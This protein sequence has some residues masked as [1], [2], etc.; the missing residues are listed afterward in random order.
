[1]ENEAAGQKIED[2]QSGIKKEGA[3]LLENLSINMDT[4]QKDIL[5]MEDVNGIKN[6]VSVWDV[7]DMKV[8]APVERL[9]FYEGSLG[10][11]V[12]ILTD[13]SRQVV[14]DSME[15]RKNLQEFLLEEEKKWSL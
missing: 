14:F 6:I 11:R 12:L 8:H 4:S 10:Y 2:S 1:M 9:V 5:E 3:E 13:E 7:A 15:F